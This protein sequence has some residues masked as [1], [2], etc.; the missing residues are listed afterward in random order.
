[1]S[2]TTCMATASATYSTSA[3]NRTTSTSTPHTTPTLLMK[4]RSVKIG[5]ISLTKIIAIGVYRISK[6]IRVV[7]WHYIP[8]HR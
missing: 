1:M 8:P 4:L 2:A 5:K 3:P 6:I 7:A